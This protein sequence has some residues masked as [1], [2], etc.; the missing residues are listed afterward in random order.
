MATVL[1]LILNGLMISYGGVYGV[2]WDP[3]TPDYLREDFGV[4]LDQ[5]KS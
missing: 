5:R 1:I 2:N 3:K 4:D